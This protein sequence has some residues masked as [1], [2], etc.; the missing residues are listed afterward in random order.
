VLRLDACHERSSGTYLLEGRGG[1]VHVP[2]RAAFAAIDDAD[3]DGLASVCIWCSVVSWLGQRV[4]LQV[5]EAVRPQL[6]S[7]QGMVFQTMHLRVLGQTYT[8]LLL[9]FPPAVGALGSSDW[10][11]CGIDSP[12]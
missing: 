8:G 1:Q 3:R 4:R 11:G 7:S 6:H 12:A 10:K 9:G 2:E 5:I